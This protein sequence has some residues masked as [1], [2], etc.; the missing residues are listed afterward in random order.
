MAD[1]KSSDQRY[2]TLN[3]K[4]YL[5]YYFLGSVSH[6]E[7][8]TIFH[9]GKVNVKEARNYIE[10]LY[11]LWNREDYILERSSYWD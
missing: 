9:T 6:E 3:G 1:F 7:W 11:P 4:L 5:S 8:Q 2:K 10:K